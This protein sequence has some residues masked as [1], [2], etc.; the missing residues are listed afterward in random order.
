M[1]TR[2]A[3]ITITT[4][5]LLACPASAGAETRFGLLPVRGSRAT[6]DWL[7][8]RLRSVLASR[9]LPVV[10]TEE[11]LR[12]LSQAP[13][14]ARALKAARAAIGEAERHNLYMKRADALAAAKRALVE[15]KAVAGLHVAPT[16]VA[17]AQVAVALA[18]LLKPPDEARALSAM[19]AAVAADPGYA[20]N[21]DRLPSRAA[22][23]LKRAHEARDPPSP[24]TLGELATLAALG[25]VER[26]IWIAVVSDPDHAEVAL[27]VYDHENRSVV[28]RYNGR[29]PKNGL[30]QKIAALVQGPLD[31]KGSPETRQL[32]PVA[33]AWTTTDK[34]A[35]RQS[36][37]A[38]RP[39]R[40]WYKRWWVWTLAGAVVVGTGVAIAA[41]AGSTSDR[42]YEF[43]VT[44]TP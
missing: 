29:L 7:G 43:H 24:P 34:S 28:T 26:V 1:A 40:P 22:R 27:L 36:T 18:K 33:P 16:L 3:A 4:L 32:K 13:E 35:P 6:A 9:G 20:P 21:P 25:K 19:R 41:S 23:L 37:P 31:T 2:L 17:R 30:A 12:S 38:T 8:G 44:H 39:P 14:V 11:M 15:L 10:G 42:T 5:L